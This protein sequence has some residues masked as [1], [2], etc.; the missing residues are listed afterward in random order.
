MQE[1]SDQFHSFHSSHEITFPN[2][3][4]ISP[5]GYPSRLEKIA[6]A[7]A[8]KSFLRRMQIV[9]STGKQLRIRLSL[10]A[11]KCDFFT[12]I[13]IVCHVVDHCRTLHHSPCFCCVSTK[14]RLVTGV[15][16]V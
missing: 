9:I 3:N 8:E 5:V 15:W 16:K 7:T 12:L 6:N 10:A 1:T 11:Q 4:T 13:T 14:L 2:K